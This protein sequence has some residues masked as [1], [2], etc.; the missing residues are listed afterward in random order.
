MEQTTE[1]AIFRWDLEFW[2]Q[3]ASCKSVHMASGVHFQ[4][5][6]QSRLSLWRTGHAKYLSHAQIGIIED[7]RSNSR[8]GHTILFCMESTAGLEMEEMLQQQ[9][10]CPGGL[11]EEHTPC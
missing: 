9:E 8:K 3:E 11:W 2:E 1:C 7:K 5:A 6:L 10:C 4:F